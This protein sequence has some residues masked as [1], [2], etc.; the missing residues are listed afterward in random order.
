MR[1]LA[2]I[3]ANT[4]YLH[5]VISITST[6]LSLTV[7]RLNSSFVSMLTLNSLR[8]SLLSSFL[9]RHHIGGVKPDSFLVKRQLT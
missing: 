2:I 9:V 5:G 3:D 6:V 7:Q 1:P 8:A 4:H